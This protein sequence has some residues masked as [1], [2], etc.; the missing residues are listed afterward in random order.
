MSVKLKESGL[1][2]PPIAKTNHTYHQTLT[3]HWLD[4]LLV[5]AGYTPV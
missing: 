5:L 1:Y 2:N 3:V 4:I